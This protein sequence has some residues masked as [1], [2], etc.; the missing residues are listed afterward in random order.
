MKDLGMYNSKQE[1]SWHCCI[2]S[3]IHV[4]LTLQNREL[5]TWEVRMPP[6]TVMHHRAAEAT[7]QVANGIGDLGRV[8]R[9]SYSELQWKQN[10]RVLTVSDS[11]SELWTEKPGIN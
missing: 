5:R 1:A 2:A 8:G 7:G 4:A 9:L 6:N 3:L 10:H 11:K